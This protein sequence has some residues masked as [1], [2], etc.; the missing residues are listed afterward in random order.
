M[1][2]PLASQAFTAHCLSRRAAIEFCSKRENLAHSCRRPLISDS[3]GAFGTADAGGVGG[4]MDSHVIS[5]LKSRVV[6]AAEQ[7]AEPQS[8]RAFGSQSCGECRY[9]E[10]VSATLPLLLGALTSTHELNTMTS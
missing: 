6:A 9:R 5:S 4:Q 7:V 3:P 1:Y 8:K 10:R 2:T